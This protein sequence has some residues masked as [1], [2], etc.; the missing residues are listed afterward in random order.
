MSTKAN[1][2][3][4]LNQLFTYASIRTHESIAHKAGLSGTD[5]KYL[6]FLIEKGKMTAGDL[7]QLTGLTSGGVTGLID[8]FEK[9]NLVTR[10][11]AEN[12]RRKVFIVPNTDDIMA[13]FIPLYREFREKLDLLLAT[14]TE[15]EMKVIE[16]YLT[17]TIKILDE[18]ADNISN[19]SLK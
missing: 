9:K 12:D 1:K 10:H 6:G 3:R 11:F 19:D 16:A 5:H 13:V 2:I 4:K 15:S 7:S 8:R 14:F 17:E 18:T